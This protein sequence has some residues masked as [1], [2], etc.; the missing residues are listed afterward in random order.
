MV[1]KLFLVQHGEAK[2]A[3]EDPERGLTPHGIQQTMRIARH[4]REMGIEVRTVYHSGKLRARQ[5]AE[6]LCTNTLSLTPRETDGLAPKDDPLTWKA[7]LSEVEGNVMLVGHLPHLEL[8]AT[9]LLIGGT[10]QPFIAFNNSGIVCLER[11]EADR[12]T[13]LWMIT[14]EILSA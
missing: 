5:T 10:V 14:P 11:S 13:L 3:H 8:L 9:E 6:I 1:R 4:V 2:P 7:R 12:W